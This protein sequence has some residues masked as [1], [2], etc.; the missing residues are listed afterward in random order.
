MKC[1]NLNFLKPCGPLQACNG[2][3]LPLLT[4]NTTKFATRVLIS[5]VPA[6]MYKNDNNLEFKTPPTHQTKLEI[7]SALLLRG[8]G[9]V[10]KKTI[11]VKCTADPGVIY[12]TNKIC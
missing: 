12:I 7:T 2:T 3:A 4:L 5:V 11:D 9:Y 8:N 1:G 10:S 6:R